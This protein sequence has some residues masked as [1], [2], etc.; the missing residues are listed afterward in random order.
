MSARNILT[1]FQFFS[2]PNVLRIV[3]ICICENW[4]FSHWNPNLRNRLNANFCH[5]FDDFSNPNLW[6][7]IHH[8]S[9]YIHIHILYCKVHACWEIEMSDFHSPKWRREKHPVLWQF[10]QINRM[11]PTTVHSFLSFCLSCTYLCTTE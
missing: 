7:P 11:L 4:D 8:Y 2:I 9:K 6:Y 5:I 10:S 3:M 1:N